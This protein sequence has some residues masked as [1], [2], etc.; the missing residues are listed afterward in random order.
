VRH[1]ELERNWQQ[2]WIAWRRVVG[3]LG[4]VEQLR[5][6]DVIDPLLA[7]AEL[8]LKRPKSF[9]PLGV[10]EILAL[11]SSLERLEHSRR[12]ELGRWLID[13]T[14]SDRDPELWTHIGRIGARV[15]AYASVH[16]VLPASVVER[17]LTELLRERWDEVR[18]AAASALSLA[19]VTGDQVRDVSPALRAEV[20]RALARAGAPEEWRRA[21][22][23]H[24]PVTH[25]ERERLL[26]DDLP[27]GLSLVDA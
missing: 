11:G 7:P 18:T 14:W 15:P 2:F 16:Y 4:P 19:R 17:W 9:R 20:E 27:L 12:S 23:E 21:V 1:R 8:K 5:V 26:G 10:S 6:R 13:K 25:G 3:G 22:T 24:V